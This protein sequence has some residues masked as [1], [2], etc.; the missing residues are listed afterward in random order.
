MQELEPV[1]VRT[2]DG[3]QQLQTQ[4]QYRNDSNRSVRLRRVP[5]D[6]EAVNHSNR[7][8]VAD[9]VIIASEARN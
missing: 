4:S 1:S 3:R 2:A 5:L 8:T 9:P 6:G 7:S